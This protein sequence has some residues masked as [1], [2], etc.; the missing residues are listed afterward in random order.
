MSYD[1]K[2]EYGKYG[3]EVPEKEDSSETG[4]TEHEAIVE[5]RAG[6]GGHNRA[7]SF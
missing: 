6:A 2:N 1:W 3:S 5:I 7:R 4:I